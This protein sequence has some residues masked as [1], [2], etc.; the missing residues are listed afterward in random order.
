MVKEVIANLDSSKMSGPGCIPVGLLKNYEPELSCILAE[1][2][3]MSLKEFGFQ[4][5]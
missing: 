4:D 5:C 2:F 3:N 1:L